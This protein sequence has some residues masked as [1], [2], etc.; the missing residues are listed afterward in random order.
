MARRR[1]A[2]VACIYLPTSAPRLRRPAQFPLGD[3]APRAG[4]ANVLPAP[5]CVSE[6]SVLCHSISTHEVP[7]V[8]SYDSINVN[9]LQWTA[10]DGSLYAFRYT[11]VSVAAAMVSY[12]RLGCQVVLTRGSACRTTPSGASRSTALRSSA[13]SAVSRLPPALRSRANQQH[14]SPRPL[15]PLCTTVGDMNRMTSQWTR[16]GGTVCFRQ[17]NIYTPLLGSVAGADAC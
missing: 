11:Q 2:S 4:H 14:L 13:T 7:C 16:G 3:L 6:P 15:P 1:S 17:G 8:D 10:S 9:D 12:M 5:V